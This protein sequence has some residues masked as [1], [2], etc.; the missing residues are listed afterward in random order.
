M[1]RKM[2]RKLV[3]IFIVVVFQMAEFTVNLKFFSDIHKNKNNQM[4]F[5]TCPS[6]HNINSMKAGALLCSLRYPYI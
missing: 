5:V 4:I 1:Y 2:S 6:H 3:I